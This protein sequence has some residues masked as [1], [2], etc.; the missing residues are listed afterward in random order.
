MAKGAAFVFGWLVSLAIVV[1]V[2]VLVAGNHPPRPEACAGRRR[3]DCVR[4]V[5]VIPAGTRGRVRRE[6]PP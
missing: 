4:L 2:T 5:I 3:A 6:G 1:T